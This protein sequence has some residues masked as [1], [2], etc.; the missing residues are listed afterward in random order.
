MPEADIGEPIG[1]LESV[2]VGDFNGDGKLDLAVAN[3]GMSVLLGNGDGTFKTAASY[4]TGLG[5]SSIAAGDFNG[6][7]KLDLVVVNSGLQGGV[8]VLLNNGDG[9]FETALS[10][11]TVRLAGR[12]P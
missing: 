10:Y 3:G 9:T 7:G 6:D 8:G 1:E 11:G 4:G 2:A 12:V 5:P